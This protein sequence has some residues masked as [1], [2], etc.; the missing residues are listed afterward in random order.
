MCHKERDIFSQRM[1]EQLW[2]LI[3]DR[4]VKVLHSYLPMGSEVNVIP[5]LQKALENDITVIV[6]R[7]LKKRQ[8]Q[9]LIVKDLKTMEVGIFNTYHPK[10]ALEYTG[11]YDLVIVP[12][13]AFDRS[14]FRVGYGAG[15]Y[16]TFLAEESTALKVGVCYPFQV[17]EQVPVEEHDVKLDIL[18]S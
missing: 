16:D 1:S 2:D 18:L 8:M 15:Y 5:V 9:N 11:A 13:L 17:M 12:G 10:N 4:K 7:S 6:P 14:G 3:V